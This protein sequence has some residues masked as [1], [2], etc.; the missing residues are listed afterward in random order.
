[1]KDAKPLPLGPFR[2]VATTSLRGQG[3]AA[4]QVSNVDG[5]SSLR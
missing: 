4:S 2:A 1:V 3:P 5:F